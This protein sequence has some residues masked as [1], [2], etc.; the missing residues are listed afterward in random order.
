MTMDP[1]ANNAL[2]AELYRNVPSYR[3]S[4]N[5][6]AL[7]LLTLVF[8]FG[9]P[10]A[11]GQV[12]AS[13]PSLLKILLAALGAPLLIVCIVVVT[14]KV[15]FDKLDNN[16]QLKTWGAANK[17]VAVLILAGWVYTRFFA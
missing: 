14:G 9:G 8:A 10:Y 11:V 3:R 13:D 17:V 4:G 6:S 12:A 15:Y 16:G 2:A 1:S 5:M 7:L